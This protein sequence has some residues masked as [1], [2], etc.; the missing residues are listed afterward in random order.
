MQI[1]GFSPIPPSPS[2]G[3]SRQTEQNPRG[4][5]S[6]NQITPRPPQQTKQTSGAQGK[7]AQPTQ[8]S[9][10]EKKQLQ[11]LQRRDQEVRAHEAAHKAVAGQHARGAATFSFQRGPDGQLY[12]VGGE[13]SI[14][15]ST[16][17]DDPEATLQKAN[18]IRAAALAPAQPSGQDLAVAA[19]AASMAAE[20]RADIATEQQENLLPKE[21]GT[22]QKTESTAEDR[23]NKAAANQ[24][25]EI[26]EA[27]TS[28]HQTLIDLIA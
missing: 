2:L 6:A 27:T 12:A 17:S 23:A 19:A 8:L 1:S 15:T 4:N 7:T 10:E 21:E 3:Y 5:D 16:I 11:E 25:N 9:E 22:T 13:V 28:N 24:Y 20:A 18:Q 26:A 14:D